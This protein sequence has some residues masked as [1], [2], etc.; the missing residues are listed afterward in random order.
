[1]R[2]QCLELPEFEPVK[3]GAS[4]GERHPGSGIS[5]CTRIHQQLTT[6]V[7]RRSISDDP[8][9]LCCAGRIH[10]ESVPRQMRHAGESDY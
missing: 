5:R 2:K 6:N 1:M 8:L 3:V 10:S 4:A 9:R 7:E